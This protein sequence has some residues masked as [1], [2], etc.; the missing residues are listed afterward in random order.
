MSNNRPSLTPEQ[1]RQA[2]VVTE[3]C[4]PT[5]FKPAVKAFLWNVAHLLPP[6][7]ERLCRYLKHHQEVGHPVALGS[8]STYKV[9]RHLGGC[10]EFRKFDFAFEGLA[11]SRLPM[12]HSQAAKNFWNILSGATPIP[13]PNS[14]SAADLARLRLEDPD[15]RWKRGEK[16]SVSPTTKQHGVHHKK[17]GHT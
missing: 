15:G 10:A 6:A 5:G 1:Q 13:S 14:A 9:G 12:T 7:F 4:G 16:M 8:N 17:L 2:D 3:L 11:A